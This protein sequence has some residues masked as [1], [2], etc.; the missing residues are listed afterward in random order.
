MVDKSTRF[1]KIKGSD[2]RHQRN[3]DCLIA[4]T[5]CLVCFISTVNGRSKTER[6]EAATSGASRGH[7]TKL[8]QSIILR[9]LWFRSRKKDGRNFF[10]SLPMYPGACTIKLCSVY[11]FTGA[12]YEVILVLHRDALF[13]LRTNRL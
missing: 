5:A 13:H 10:H 12:L 6:K 9:C 1:P 7:I 8:R 11:L 3:I 4:R 2:Y